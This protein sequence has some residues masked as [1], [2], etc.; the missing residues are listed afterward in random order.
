MSSTWTWS[1]ELSFA[2]LKNYDYDYHHLLVAVDRKSRNPQVS[3]GGCYLLRPNA[4]DWA[5]SVF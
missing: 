3:N 4:V 1:Y 5:N 2:M